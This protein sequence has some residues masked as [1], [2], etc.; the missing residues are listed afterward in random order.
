MSALTV[1][2][3]ALKHFTLTLK[4]F[5]PPEDVEGKINPELVLKF[6]TTESAR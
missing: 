5:L 1:D 2:H 6:C 4:N 3:E